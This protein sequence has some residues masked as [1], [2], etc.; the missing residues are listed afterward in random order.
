MYTGMLA[1]FENSMAARTVRRITLGSTPH[2]DAS[3]HISAVWSRASRGGTYQR[4]YAGKKTRG[5]VTVSRIKSVVIA[6]PDMV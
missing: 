5:P 1:D 2:R 6:P 4:K 3:P